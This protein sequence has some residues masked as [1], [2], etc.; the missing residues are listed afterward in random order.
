MSASPFT[1]LKL[2]HYTLTLCF[3]DDVRNDLYV[4][5]V[6][7]EFKKGGK[8]SDKNVE[9][10]MCV[11]NQHGKVLEVRAVHMPAHQLYSV[12]LVFMYDVSFYGC[13]FVL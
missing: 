6:Q 4:T 5:L 3:S 2:L 10:T 7:G 11:C 1:S 13:I 9:V 8:Y 12:P